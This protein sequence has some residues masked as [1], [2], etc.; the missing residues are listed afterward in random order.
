M[1]ERPGSKASFGTGMPCAR[2]PRATASAMPSGDLLD[3]RRRRRRTCRR[4]RSRRRG[5]ARAPVATAS[6]LGVHG[7][8]A[9]GRLG[10]PGGVEDLR[11]DVAVQ[12]EEVER[13]VRR[14]CGVPS[15]TARS[16]ETPN[17]WS[18]CAVARNSCVERVHAAVHAEPHGAARGRRVPRHPRPARSRCSLSMMIAPTPAR[19]GRARSRRRD[20]LLPWKP[21]RAGSA[22]AASA[23]ASSPP[24]QTSTASPASVTQRTTAAERNALPA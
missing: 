10:E 9:L 21:M 22:P 8:Q 12:A 15:S 23:T 19:D 11:A 5:S 4:C 2:H 7:E 1:I 18:S 17:F 6:E 3:R 16:S 20:L 13:V 14:G 24:V